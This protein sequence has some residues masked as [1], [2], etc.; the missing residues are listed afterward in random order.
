MYICKGFGKTWLKCTKLKSVIVTS[1]K[2]NS[3]NGK[4]TAIIFPQNLEFYWWK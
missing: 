3:E 4:E 1:K 2:D